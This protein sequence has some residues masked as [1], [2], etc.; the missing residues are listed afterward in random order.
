MVG[1][2]KKLYT[3]IFKYLSVSSY[4]MHTYLDTRG[5]TINSPAPP[6]PA[7]SPGSLVTY[8]L[9]PESKL[10]IPFSPHPSC[11]QSFSSKKLI[12]LAENKLCTCLIQGWYV[13]LE[14]GSK[15]QLQAISSHGQG[16]CQL[17]HTFLKILTSLLHTCLHYPTCSP[18][19][20]DCRVLP[21]AH[22]SHPES[23]GD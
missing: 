9:T 15:I 11:R 5:S 14:E 20:S 17:W 23:P 19:A 8:L 4:H 18:P 16:I 13:L 10:I 2:G 22:Q 3:S 12:A 6:K 1:K 7:C 21:Y